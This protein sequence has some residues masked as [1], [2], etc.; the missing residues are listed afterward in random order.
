MG[1]VTCP[2]CKGNKKIMVLA[3]PGA[4]IVAMPCET[5]RETGEI[6]GQQV[7]WIKAGDAMREVRIARGLTLRK[8]AERRGM[9]ALALSRMERGITEPVRSEE[10]ADARGGA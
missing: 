7:G 8:E 10:D 5:C 9:S 4:R 1:A 2:E 6:S 3:C